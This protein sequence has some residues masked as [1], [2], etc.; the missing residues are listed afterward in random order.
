MR[1][2]GPQSGRD[3]FRA[4]AAY[5]HATHV[6]LAAGTV[7]APAV[8]FAFRPSSPIV[9][10][11]AMLAA[12]LVGVGASLLVAAEFAPHHRLTRRLRGS[13]S[14]A[15]ASGGTLVAALVVAVSVPATGH[16]VTAA[17]VPL[18]WALRAASGGSFWAGIIRLLAATLAGGVAVFAVDAGWE[19][20]RE[21]LTLV[22]AA[23]LA[24]GV[25]GQDS[26]YSLAIELDDLR[27]REA[28][29]AVLTERK[30]FAGDLHDIQG[31]HLG[32]I[33]VEAEL[34]RRL[35]ARADYAAATRHAERI[36]ATT[37]EALDEMRRV[38]H[39]NR[40]VRLD[41]EIA[42]AVRVLRAAGITAEHDLTGRS[43]TDAGTDR[44][45][46]L[47]VR[48]AIT[49]ILKHTHADR[50]AITTRQRE[51]AGRDGIALTVTDSG[52]P[53]TAPRDPSGTGLSTLAERYRRLGGEL[54]FTGG[55]GDGGGRLAGWLPVSGPNANGDTV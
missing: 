13:R 41:E 26:I 50:C 31:Q 48:E 43:G 28:E 39:A 45:L 16:P 38:V 35:I 6:I 23:L 27:S 21:P 51:R 30:R 9:V 24:L 49:N 44:L 53:A 32:L 33:T 14:R 54:H 17:A 5:V 19:H 15:W 20:A 46:G 25:L 12:V 34:V 10:S 18:A 37:L 22:V 11:V 42:N 2:R 1:G 4:I 29:R 55:D 7:I 47:T 3:R 8:A 40:E 52:P 36:Q